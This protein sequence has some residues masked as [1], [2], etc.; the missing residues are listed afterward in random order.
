MRDLRQVAL[1]AGSPT[2]FT[3]HGLIKFA[4]ARKMKKKD[5]EEML[6]AHVEWRLQT[7]VDGWIDP[8][9]VETQ[10]LFDQHHP[11]GYTTT[12]SGTLVMFE[13]QKHTN[14][15][16]LESLI[17]GNQDASLAYAQARVCARVEQSSRR[18]TL[19]ASMFHGRPILNTT[20]VKDLSGMGVVQL[21]SIA[22][23]SFSKTS[24]KTLSDHYPES[25]NKVYV[26]NAPRGVGAAWAIV[27]QF[28]DANT[29]SKVVGM[30]YVYACISLTPSRTHSLSLARSLPHSRTGSRCRSRCRGRARSLSRFRCRCRAPAL[31]LALSLV[32]CPWI[33]NLHNLPNLTYIYIYI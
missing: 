1:G 33:P 15:D 19:A 18:F 32:I 9:P 22:R 31:D 24:S 25:L 13:Q 21:V 26:V 10:K 16:G 11:I 17:D 3:D 4:R 5:A 2:S 8:Y 12:A 6:R 28:L 7:N 23:K 29:A 30:L 27:K 20:M 14:V